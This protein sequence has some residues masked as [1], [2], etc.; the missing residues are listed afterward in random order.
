MTTHSFMAV[1]AQTTT[2][3][4]DEQPRQSAG[5]R[6]AYELD[7]LSQLV[8]E[9]PTRSRARRSTLLV[10][11]RISLAAATAGVAAWWLRAYAPG[12]LRVVC[13]VALLVVA[14][15]VLP[16]RP[17]APTRRPV[18]RLG[19]AALLLAAVALVIPSGGRVSVPAIVAVAGGAAVYVAVATSAR[20]PRRVLCF[21]SAE[22]LARLTKAVP[23]TD[24]HY[25]PVL[26]G[27]GSHGSHLLER[28]S[29]ERVDLVVVGARRLGEAGLA[30]EVA[31]LYAGD[32]RVRTVGEFIEELA[33]RV[34]VHHLSVRWFLRDVM[35]VHN[36][37]YRGLRYALD[38]IVGT[39]GCLVLLL[40]LPFLAAAI[41][42]DSRG[43]V[44]Y[45]QVRVGRGRRPFRLVKLRT[46]TCDAEAGGPCFATRAD[47]RITRVGRFLRRSRLDELP[48]VWNVLR[49]D[50]TLI[51]P[52]PERPE[53]VAGSFGQ[54]PYYDFRHIVRPGVTGWAQVTEGYAADL[55]G[56]VRKLERDLYY[57][58][59]QGVALDVRVLVLTVMCILRMAGR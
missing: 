20:R 32:V 13:A 12:P 38:L 55:D 28:C 41:K 2:D 21:C 7:A 40:L 33:G 35:A 17:F 58:R 47:P 48:Q 54:I 51:G 29:Q 14:P 24:V 53:F 59:H 23:P 16:G 9:E 56:A 1:P 43:P 42:M 45:R 50:M 31:E 19:S 15:V 39:V 36:R 44:F 30:E 49:G 27:A 8:V 3:A 22:E 11:V 37:G 18:D 6:T 57:L 26:D 10:V 25:L 46:M 34:P 52:R 5:Q 4:L